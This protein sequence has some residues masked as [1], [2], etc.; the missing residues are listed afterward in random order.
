MKLDAAFM[1]RWCM[2]DWP[3]DDALEASL[4]DNPA[5]L[6]IV[7]HCRA[8]VIARQIKGCM[9][10]PRA[11]LYGTALLRGKLSLDRVMRSTIRKSMTDAQWDQVKPPRNLINDCELVRELF[12]A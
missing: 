3:I 12:A 1:D 2:L 9:V 6:E 8:Q 4:C 11:T 5:W 10:T 7:R